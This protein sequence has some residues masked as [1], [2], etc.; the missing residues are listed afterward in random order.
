MNEDEV[1]MAA[2]SLHSRGPGAR[3]RHTLIVKRKEMTS[4]S[5]RASLRLPSGQFTH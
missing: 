4:Q 5:T 1:L 3:T 2:F